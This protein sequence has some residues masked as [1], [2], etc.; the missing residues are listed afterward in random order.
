MDV[1]D[2]VPHRTDRTTLL[3]VIG[4]L[5]AATLLVVLAVVVYQRADRALRDQARRRVKEDTALAARLVDEQTLRFSE[6][7]R[8]HA[9][10]LAALGDRP[11]MTL[12]APQRTRAARELRALVTGTRGLRGAGLIAPDGRLLVA[13]PAQPQF[14]GRSFA[15]RDWYRGVTRNGSPYVSRVFRS[16]G[17]GHPKTVTVASVVRSAKTGQVIGILTVGLEKRT[18]ELAADIT[19]TQGLGLV[20]TDQSGNVIAATGSS[21]PKIE[22]RHSDPLVQM[23]LAGRSGT[24]T[25]NDAIAGYAPIPSTGWTVTARLPTNVA[26]ED[27]HDL[28]SLVILLTIA[29]GLLLALLTGGAVLLARRAQRLSFAH[30]KRQ[31]AMHLHD[32]VV[33]TLTLAQGAREAGND[34]IADRAVADALAESKRI[35]AELLPDDLQPGDLVRRDG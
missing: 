4:G 13:D 11:L 19:R 15:Y 30:V 25:S 24:Q 6:I 2:S 32:G 31:Q 3:A 34:E 8:A 18:Q 33:Q 21:G 23:A 16:A 26:L 7:V 29:I 22:S 12:T 1:G 14:Y 27:V 9:D 17:P 5:V 20:V 35:T 10:N 28:R